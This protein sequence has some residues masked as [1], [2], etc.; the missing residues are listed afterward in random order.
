MS[1]RKVRVVLELEVSELNDDDLMDQFLDHTANM[2]MQ[3]FIE[4]R[5]AGFA[6]PEEGEGYPEEAT[7]KVEDVEVDEITNSW[8]DNSIQFPR[9]LAE[10]LATQE[11]LDWSAL[12]TS[13]DLEHVRQLDEL[14]ERADREWERIK[15]K[16][17][18][19]T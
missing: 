3:D 10:I 13:M 12:C 19:T 18:P 9:L 4:R 7:I 14:F 6:F 16:T 15:A 8:E 2:T 11:D 5:G 17:C 1:T